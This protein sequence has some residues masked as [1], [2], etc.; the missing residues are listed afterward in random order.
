MTKAQDKGSQGGE[1]QAKSKAL[2][3][4]TDSIGISSTLAHPSTS[5]RVLYSPVSNIPLQGKKSETRE[6][7]KAGKVFCH[8]FIFLC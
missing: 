3:L 2:S 1:A 5:R 6:I 4:S 7:D 8:I